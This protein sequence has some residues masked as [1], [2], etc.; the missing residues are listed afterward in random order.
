[1]NNKLNTWLARGRRATFMEKAVNLHKARWPLCGSLP[2]GLTIM[3]GHIS[4]NLQWKSSV[5]KKGYE[6]D[7]RTWSIPVMPK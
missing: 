4:P 2:R 5:I 1:M 3:H 7:A 6:D